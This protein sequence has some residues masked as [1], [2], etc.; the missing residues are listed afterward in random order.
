MLGAPRTSI[1]A[2]CDGIDLHSSTVLLMLIYVLMQIGLNLRSSTDCVRINE[3]WL[4]SNGDVRCL[5]TPR[6]SLLLLG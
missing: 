5:P 4:L 2:D 3:K 1:F 6:P